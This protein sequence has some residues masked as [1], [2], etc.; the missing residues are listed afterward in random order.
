MSDARPMSLTL[1]A[2]AYR[3]QTG[4]KE[5]TPAQ[6]RRLNSKSRK[7]FGFVSWAWFAAPAKTSRIPFFTELTPEE[8]FHQRH[9][10]A[11]SLVDP[12]SIIAITG[13]GL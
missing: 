12:K 6:R 2:E 4:R 7:R 8:K 13:T 11:G 10:F 3:R 1:R 5:P 9:A